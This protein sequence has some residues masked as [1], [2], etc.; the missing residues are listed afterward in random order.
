MN[1]CE[2]RFALV[3]LGLAL[4]TQGAAAQASS[5]ALRLA[6]IFSDGLV[7]QRGA[8][9]PVWGQAAPRSAVTVRFRGGT[10]RAM[11]DSAGR[12]RATLPASSAGGPFALTVESGAER[13]IVHDVLVGDVWVASGQSNMEFSVSVAS[14]AAETIAAAHDSA[15]RELKV[16]NSWAEHPASDI[17]AG[18]W[19]PAD[20]QHVGAFSA[21]AYFFARDLRAAEHVPIGIV[22]VTWGGSA[23]ETWTSAAGQGLGPEGAATALARERA[24]LDS[25]NRALSARFGSLDHDPGLVNGVAVWASPTLG[26][27]GWSSIHVPDL[28][29]AQGYAEVD[30]IAWYRTTVTLSAEEAGQD[31]ALSLGTIDDDD[32]TWVNGVEVGRTN[33]WNAPRHYRVPASA[34]HAGGNVIAVRVHDG[35]GGGGIYGVADSL[36]LDVGRVSHALAGSW[37][38]R[39]GE[40]GLQMDGQRLNKIPAITWNQ[41]VHPLLP[42]AI[43]GVIWYQGESNAEDERE[44]RA[45][46]AQFQQLIRSWRREWN[47]GREPSF[48]FLW[49]QLPNYMHP[50]STPTAT[51]GAWA[52]HRESMAGALALP[53]TGQAITI[54]VGEEI[55]IHPRNKADVGKRLALV[56]RKVAYGEKVRASGPTYRSHSVR[57]GKVIVRFANVGGGLTSR[58]SDG[59]VGAFAVAGAD[60]RFVWAQARIEGDHVVV[61][62]DS[63]KSPVAVRYAWANN[64]VGANLYNREGLPAAPFRTDAW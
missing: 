40:I 53:R 24:H 56:A 35:G 27:S 4:A 2:S 19:A 47:G 5:G 39:L 25:V 50:D 11:A 38:F 14:N 30:G 21:V 46:R 48:P 1:R 61:W 41:M 33:G 60:H 6:K 16:P 18:S 57:D 22:N 44:A 55:D 9:I 45:Y 54:D 29:E 31:A 13:A 20:S 37:K 51:G 26:D 58:A 43:K 34:L 59:S 8:P 10:A 42:I 32:V 64:P 17:V 36:H 28:W 49:V 3:L 12:W 62:S 52:I 63:V 7:V 15:L 23:I